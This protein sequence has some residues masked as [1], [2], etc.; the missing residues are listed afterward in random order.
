MNCYGVLQFILERKQFMPFMSFNLLPIWIHTIASNSHVIA[1]Y[2]RE[3]DM[4][5]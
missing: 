1:T 3:Y 2:I 5:F 4:K